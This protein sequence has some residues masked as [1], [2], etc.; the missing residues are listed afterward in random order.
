MQLGSDAPVSATL[1]HVL[2]QLQSTHPDRVIVR[3]FNLDAPVRCDRA[4]IAQVLSN[5]LGNALTHGA[6][7]TPV[8]VEAASGSGMF[9][10][11]VSNLGDPIPG[12]LLPKLFHPFVRGADDSSSQGLGLG[13]YIA[14]EIARA[15][16]GTLSATSTPAET[17]FVFRMPSG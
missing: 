8:R 6:A 9:E 14:S 2:H 15:H 3:Q 12:S 5:L 13:L 7:A 4:R 16:G 11:A 17:R 1:P 10:L